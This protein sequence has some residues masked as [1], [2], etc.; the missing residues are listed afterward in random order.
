VRAGNNTSEGFIAEQLPTEFMDL[1]RVGE[2]SG[3]MD[4]VTSK[5]ADITA[6]RA[7]FWF[8]IFAKW[9]PKVVYACVC[10]MMIIMLFKGF[11]EIYGGLGDGY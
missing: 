7:E 4:K 8:E 2:E 1:W 6:D 5:L 3:S 9:L 11:G 10:I